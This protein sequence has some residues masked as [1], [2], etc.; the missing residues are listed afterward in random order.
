M[1][2]D[3]IGRHE[4]QNGAGIVGAILEHQTLEHLGPLLQDQPPDQLI[5][6]GLCHRRASEVDHDLE[7]LRQ[8]VLDTLAL[9]SG[10]TPHAE[11]APFA[12]ALQGDRLAWCGRAH[13]RN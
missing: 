1:L 2:I 7:T 9:G 5:G 8:V 10:G 4:P 13:G 6:E 12:R 11:E 3:T